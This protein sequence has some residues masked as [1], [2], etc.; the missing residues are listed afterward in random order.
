MNTSLSPGQ[1]RLT[2]RRDIKGWEQ[3]GGC[4]PPVTSPDATTVPIDLRPSIQVSKLAPSETSCVRIPK[5][6]NM[7]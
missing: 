6:C 3:G 4:A 5:A 7:K 1:G 2:A